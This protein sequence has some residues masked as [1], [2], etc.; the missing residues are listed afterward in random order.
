M[1]VSPPEYEYCRQD[2]ACRLVDGIPGAARSC[3]QSGLRGHVCFFQLVLQLIRRWSSWRRWSGLFRHGSSGEG[4]S[5]FGFLR[6][7]CASDRPWLK[8]LDRRLCAWLHLLPPG[9]GVRLQVKDAGRIRLLCSAWRRPLA[10]SSGWLCARS[11]GTRVMAPVL[12]DVAAVFFES[13]FEDATHPEPIR[14]SR[15]AA[16]LVELPLSHPSAV[17]VGWKATVAILVADWTVA[18][19]V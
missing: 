5:T 14:V 2:V 13:R 6:A 17:L 15:I 19:V 12:A 16:S 18:A 11:T 4:M 1:V 7:G 3:L 10:A 8:A 9:V